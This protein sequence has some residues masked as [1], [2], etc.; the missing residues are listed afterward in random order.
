MKVIKSVVLAFIALLGMSMA[1]SELRGFG[2]HG[3]FVAE[4]VVTPLPTSGV[5]SSVVSSTACGATVGSAPSGTFF[6]YVVDD[7]TLSAHFALCDGMSATVLQKINT[8]MNTGNLIYDLKVDSG[9]IYANNIQARTLPTSSPTFKPTAK[10]TVKP[11]IRVG[12]GG[13]GGVGGG[14]NQIN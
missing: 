11:T 4:A 12:G 7:S 1:Q 5:I 3:G 6:G 2:G 13:G 8:G 14:N 9:Y 10:P